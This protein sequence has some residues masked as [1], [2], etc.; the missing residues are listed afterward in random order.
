MKTVNGQ[1]L[2][3]YAGTYHSD[4]GQDIVVKLTPTEFTI[5]ETASAPVA[6]SPISETQFV[7]RTRHDYLVSFRANQSGVFN[8][9]EI[10]RNGAHISA[11]R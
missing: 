3:S 7:G 8:S 10:T 9:L 5:Q 2:A 1:T 6:L 11:R 4:A